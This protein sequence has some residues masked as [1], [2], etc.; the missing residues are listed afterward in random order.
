MLRKFFDVDWKIRVKKFSQSRSLKVNGL[1]SL[2]GI[3]IALTLIVV[4]PK[5]YSVSWTGFGSFTKPDSNFVPP[6][7][8]WDWMQLFIIPI[9]LAGVVFLLNRSERK[10]EREIAE[11]RQRE[12]ALQS[13][14]DRMTDL[15]LKE[16]LQSTENEETRDVARIRTLTVLRGLDG[17]RKGLVLLFL[18][19]AGLIIGKP[20]NHTNEKSTIE[21]TASQIP[22]PDYPIISLRGADL[23]KANLFE[24]NLFGA[25]LS[26][27]DLSGADLTK[28]DLSETK[29]SK[30]ILTN[31]KLIEAKAN[32]DEEVVLY[33]AYLAGTELKNLIKIEL[34]GVD[35]T[36]ANL[37]GAN[38]SKV[39]LH[40]A[41]LK[42]ANLSGANLT[43][44]DLL[45]AD[46]SKA[47][48]TKANLRGSNLCRVD[49]TGANLKGVDLT[50][51][52]L[53]GAVV[54]IP[55][56]VEGP[57][58]EVV[59]AQKMESADISNARP[60]SEPNQNL[61]FDLEKETNLS[62]TS[63]QDH[64][65]EELSQIYEAHRKGKLS[66][67]QLKNAKS[68]IVSEAKSLKYAIM[69]DWSKH[70]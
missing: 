35:L 61:S 15:L 53:T 60:I 19:E 30:A 52:N 54:T 62:E 40:R 5:G 12:M 70:K 37:T 58:S 38:L 65:I 63:I 18:Y 32:K 34:T 47:D 48:L 31:S 56:M 49:L 67:E 46:L 59:Q 57:I 6:K 33:N 69:P 44:A 14:L 4:I 11:D 43:S 2:A 16:K 26:G 51:A 1:W 41:K 24:A 68:Q 8:L 50:R 23:T 10:N 25:D 7:M 13:Y 20:K 22:K 29:L 45:G 9:L 42:G 27:A 28:A 64:N 3:L 39:H 36:E 66:D 17:K 21:V 55:K